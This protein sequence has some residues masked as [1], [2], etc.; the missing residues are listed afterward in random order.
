MD[1][2]VLNAA[3]ERWARRPMWTLVRRRDI[4]GMPEADLLSVYRDHGVVPKSSRADNFNKPGEDLSA[5]R[6]VRPGDLVLNKMKTWQG[7]L[8][9]SEH[10]GIVSPAYFVCEISPQVDSRYAHHLLRSEPYIHMYKTASKGIRPNQWDLPFDEFRKLPMLLPP[11]EEQRKIAAFIDL[12]STRINRLRSLTQRQVLLAHARFDE[13]MRKMTTFEDQR[14]MPTGVPWMPHVSADW[15]VSRIGY[16]FTTCGGT[17]PSSGSTDYFNGP[18]PWVNSSDVKDAPIRNVSKTLSTAALADFSSLRLCP[19]GSL[20]IALYGQGATKGRVGIL[21][22]EACLNQ[23]CCAL[24]STGRV[25]VEF[26]FYWFRAHKSGIVTHAIGAGQP[27]LS[28]E[29][30]RQLRIPVP[31]AETQRQI[32]AKLRKIEEQLEAHRSLL[33][34]RDALL[35]ER[36]QALITAAVTGQIDVSTASGR[37]VTEG[38]T[39]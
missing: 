24:L 10:E 32:V 7:S 26:A 9:V 23:A 31:D 11:L 14:G 5:Y 3:P 20:I 8:G 37:N 16:E 33:E 13:Q 1:F 35:A 30:V 12:E 18:H 21:E 22:V 27:N 28:Q 4:T 34:R 17:T 2:G 25:T 29:L 15:T 38:V 19:P 6:Y 39:V 36:R